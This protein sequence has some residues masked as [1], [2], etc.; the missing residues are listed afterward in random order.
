MGESCPPDRY[1]PSGAAAISTPR[2]FPRFPGNILR[3]FAKAFLYFLSFGIIRVPPTHL[4]VRDR[5]VSNVTQ[6]SAA[7]TFL[8]LDQTENPDA[9]EARLLLQLNQ[10]EVINAA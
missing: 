3:I 7:L 10:V 9:H 6:L 2:P 8:T 1:R 4:E 5:R